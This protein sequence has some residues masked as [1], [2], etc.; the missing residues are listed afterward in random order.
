MSAANGE[1]R[2]HRGRAGERRSRARWLR[3]RRASTDRK[4]TRL[5][6]SHMSISYAVFCLKKKNDIL[7]DAQSAMADFLNAPRLDEIIFA[8]SMSTL[9]LHMS[10]L[11]DQN[12]R[13]G[14]NIMI[15]RIDYES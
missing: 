1:H 5:N 4:S 9:T 11:L 14:D 7:N 15:T 6:S 13:A 8:N 12:F 10:R 3:I 2:S